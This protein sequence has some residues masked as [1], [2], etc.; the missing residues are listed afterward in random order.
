MLETVVTDVAQQFLQSWDF[1]DARTAER[2]ERIIGEETVA[3]VA[4]DFSM[5]IVRGKP[6]KAHGASLYAPHAG[7]KGV[8]FPYRARDDLLKMHLYFV[9]EMFG[10]VAAVETHGLVR[11]VSVVVVP[12]EQSAWRFRRELQ[13]MH[14]KHPAHIHFAGAREQRIAHHAHHCARHNTKIFFE[15]GP[16]LHR[17]APSSVIYKVATTGVIHFSCGTAGPKVWR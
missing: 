1:H 3:G 9:E 2:F 4:T 11:I 14:G 7:A 12:V 8:F 13:R 17:G 15:R 10:Q 6:R 16:A 5:H